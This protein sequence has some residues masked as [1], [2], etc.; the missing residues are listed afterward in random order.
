ML[1]VGHARQGHAHGALGKR[2]QSARQSGDVALHLA[3]RF[4][5]E[6]AKIGDDQF[7][8]A[9]GG[10]QLEAQR[11]DALHQRHFHEMMNVFRGRGF[12]HCG[13]AAARSACCRAPQVCCQL[14]S[15]DAG[16]SI[17]RAQAR[18]TSGS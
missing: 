15:Q 9:A 13:S 11:A 16:F 17:A 12:D 14:A 18:S 8:A 2:R 10:V 1:Q 5:H 4:H 6:E 3:R 7:V